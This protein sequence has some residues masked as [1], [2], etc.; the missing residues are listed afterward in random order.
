M[1]NQAARSGGA[2]C[3]GKGDVNV[4]LLNKKVVNVHHLT[5]PPGK[6]G[7]IEPLLSVTF[8]KLLIKLLILTL[9]LWEK[10]GPVP[11][12]KK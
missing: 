6:Q 8:S 11:R 12:T 5:K 2:G 1:L 4:H 7:G 3:S 10:S 9:V